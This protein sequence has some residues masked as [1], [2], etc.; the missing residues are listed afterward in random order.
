[1]SQRSISTLVTSASLF[2]LLGAGTTASAQGVCTYT[3]REALRECPVGPG[4][5]LCVPCAGQPCDYVCR[6]RQALHL[7]LPPPPARCQADVRCI[8]RDCTLFL[9]ADTGGTCSTWMAMTCSQSKQL[10][11]QRGAGQRGLH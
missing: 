3:V 7:E 8:R 4:D 6:L 11:A 9:R 10:C 5:R 1:M 2:I